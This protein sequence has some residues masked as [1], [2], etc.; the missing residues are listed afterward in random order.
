LLNF[1]FKGCMRI[2]GLLEL[3]NIVGHSVLIMLPKS[4]HTMGHNYV[5]NAKLHA[6]LSQRLAMMIKTVNTN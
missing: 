1:Y 6:H 4:E 2:L 5:S 3:S